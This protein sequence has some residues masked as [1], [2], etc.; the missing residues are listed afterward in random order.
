MQG[1]SPELKREDL[2]GLKQ[3]MFFNTITEQMWGRDTGFKF[4]IAATQHKYAKFLSK[5]DGGGYR[6]LEEID[7]PLVAKAIAGAI[8]KFRPT[9]QEEVDGPNNTRKMATVSLVDT[10]YLFGIIVTEDDHVDSMAMMALSRTKIKAYKE[11]N[12][13]IRQYIAPGGPQNQPPIYAHLLRITAFE[14]PAKQ[15]SYYVPRIR[16]A[17]PRGIAASLLPKDSPLFIAAKEMKK[18]VESGSAKVNYDA[19]GGSDEGG[20]DGEPPF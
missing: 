19:D 8:D 5:D 18:L 4:V 10:F 6:G 16:P 17:D 20:K 13:R 15:N 11:M 9:I 2:D 14:P 7:S 3:G 12:T 1:L